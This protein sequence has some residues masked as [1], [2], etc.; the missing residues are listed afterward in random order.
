MKDKV[1]SAFLRGRYSKKIRGKKSSVIFN[2]KNL[3]IREI[4]SYRKNILESIGYEMLLFEYKT[5]D[6][7]IES[8]SQINSSHNLIPNKKLG[9][10]FGKI[11]AR[12]SSDFI[13]TIANRLISLQ[14]SIDFKLIQYPLFENYDSK[15]L[16]LITKI[17][18]EQLTLEKLEQIER[19]LYEFFKK[20]RSA[21]SHIVDR[22]LKI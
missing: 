4:H 10:F 6:L 19:S 2:N 12:S 11:L 18:E 20:F 9:Y 1:I 8:N 13:S 14:K 5:K 21:M 3:K 22:N 7:E 16:I 15:K 17:H